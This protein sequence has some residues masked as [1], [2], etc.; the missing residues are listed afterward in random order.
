MWTGVSFALGRSEDIAAMAHSFRI[1]KTPLGQVGF[2]ATERGLRRVYLP[3]RTI[4]AATAAIRRH[5]PDALEDP[6]LLP[7]LASALER[8]FAGEQVEEFRVKLDWSGYSNFEVDVWRACAR[9]AYGETA[10]YKS[11]ADSIGCPGAARA[12]GMAMSHNPC[13]IVVPCHRV[14]KSDGSIGGFSAPGGIA[15]KRQLLDMEAAATFALR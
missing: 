5:T 13:P 12:V 14:L 15:Q 8:Y 6:A 9:I 2:V 7:D 1:V 3:E 11:L 4:A 10:S